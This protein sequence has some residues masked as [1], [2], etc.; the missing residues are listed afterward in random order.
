MQQNTP[1][2]RR[3]KRADLQLTKF[4]DKIHLASGEKFDELSA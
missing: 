2:T 4:K 3:A 1:E